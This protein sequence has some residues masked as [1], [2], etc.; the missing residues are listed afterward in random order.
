VRALRS[1]CFTLIEL[2]VVIAII[3][4]LVAVLL[5]A[6]AR[7]REQARR[8]ICAANLRTMGIGVSIYGNDHNGA[9]PKRWVRTHLGQGLWYLVYIVRHWETLEANR[10]EG[11]GLIRD[12]L[13]NSRVMYCPSFP[14]ESTSE[15]VDGSG[16]ANKVSYFVWSWSDWSW[17]I[18]E[19][20][21]MVGRTASGANSDPW[22]FI[23]SDRVSF[24][25]TSWL[26]SNHPLG[27]S[28]ST[29]D[30]EGGNVL[31]NDLSVKWCDVS[32]FG[33][34]IYTLYFYPPGQ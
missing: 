10:P 16:W 1:K 29:L 33:G 14:I 13:K 31:Y 5:P 7:S 6:L 19:H 26:T 15:P 22:T 27:S 3:A 4:V 21:S 28:M 9:Y 25:Y 24:Y 20:H 23:A 30:C 32:E 12:Y 18:D 8:A 17:E 2:L 11:T 34:P